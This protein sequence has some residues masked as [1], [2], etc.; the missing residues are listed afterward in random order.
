MKAFMCR[1]IYEENFFLRSHKSL[2]KPYPVAHVKHFIADL[3]SLYS[4]ERH[5]DGQAVG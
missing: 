5:F 1:P 4:H 2:S 3:S